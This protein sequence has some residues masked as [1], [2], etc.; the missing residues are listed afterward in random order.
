MWMWHFLQLKISTMYRT[1][2][3][4]CVIN[5]T[6]W[7]WHFFWTVKIFWTVQMRPMPNRY[8]MYLTRTLTNNKLLPS[9]SAF[10]LQDSM[11]TTDWK[12]SGHLVSLIKHHGLFAHTLVTFLHQSNVFFTR[13]TRKSWFTSWPT[14]LNPRVLTQNSHALPITSIQGVF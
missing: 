2:R 14:S 3:P 4:W 13:L 11:S 5:D 6:R 8:I 9:Y 12:M 1:N 10:W 7:V